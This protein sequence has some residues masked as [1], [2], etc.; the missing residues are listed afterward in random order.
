[1]S[2]GPLSARSAVSTCL[3]YVSRFGPCLEEEQEA[4]TVPLLFSDVTCDFVFQGKADY[5]QPSPGDAVKIWLRW[6]LG[7]QPN[8][9][10][11]LSCMSRG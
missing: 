3:Q 9:E 7:D 2:S 11:A 1:M 8:H 6:I 5:D 10:K 4:R